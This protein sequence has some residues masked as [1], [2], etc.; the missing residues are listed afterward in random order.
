MIMKK[1]IGILLIGFLGCLGCSDNDDATTTVDQAV[2]VAPFG[3]ID[4]TTPTYEWIP[5]PGATKYLLLVE[6]ID[7]VPVIEQWYTPVEGECASE[8]GLCSVTPD[9]DVA[10]DTWKVQACAEE[11]CGLWSDDLQ[12]EVRIY[13]PNPPLRFTNNGDG[14]VTDNNTKLMWSKNANLCGW[15]SW[16]EA[17]SFCESSTLGDHSDWC[18][19]SLSELNS[20]IDRSHLNPAMPTGHPFTNVQ[21]YHYW[22]STI[23][24]I[25]TAHA[26]DVHFNSGVIFASGKG[27]Q[28]Y[29]WCS[30]RPLKN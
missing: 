16:W 3:I 17:V 7:D 8:E 6:D 11:E 30:R 27:L 20:L 22:S 12:F 21:S 13:G 26:M 19:P 4:T 15:T 23:S 9:I 25:N 2:P 5:V 29:G 28:A 24:P 10:G 14:T 1:I 18:L